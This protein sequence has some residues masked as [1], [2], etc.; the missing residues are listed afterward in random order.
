M[1]QACKSL[2]ISMVLLT[3]APSLAASTKNWGKA[4]DVGVGLLGLAAIG[5][6]LAGNGIIGTDWDGLLQA[7]GSM[8]LAGG[9]AQGLK[10]FIHEERP[11]HSDSKSFPSAHTS[12]A[13]SAAMTLE[14]RYGWQVGLPATVVAT[15][16]G[17]ARVEAKKHHWYDVV[18][19]AALGTGSAFLITRPLDRSVEFVPWA[20]SHGGGMSA[21]LRF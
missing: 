1:R 11:D 16:V 9:A 19:G 4:S 6:P 18:A 13:F 5:V 8:A 10:Q 3:A 14:R 20:D 2:A 15:F 7:G 17:V 12:V 21:S